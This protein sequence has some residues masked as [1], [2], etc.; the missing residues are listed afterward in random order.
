MVS[1]A[2]DPRTYH[3]RLT[4]VGGDKAATL[5]SRTVDYQR[6]NGSMTNVDCP[7]CIAGADRLI[8]QIMREM[9]EILGPFLKGTP[10]PPLA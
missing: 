9:K 5:C 10:R 8:D 6:A 4:T 2:D 1:A 7:E 3:R